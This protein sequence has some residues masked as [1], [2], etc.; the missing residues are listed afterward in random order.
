M[1]DHPYIIEEH[2]I[3]TSESVPNPDPENYPEQNQDQPHRNLHPVGKGPRRRSIMRHCGNVRLFQAM[4]IFGLCFFSALVIL[5][6][7]R[8]ILVR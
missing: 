5:L 8:Y 1:D 6:F 7:V 2:R 4:L 3:L